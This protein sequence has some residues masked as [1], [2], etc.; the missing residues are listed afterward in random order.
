MGTQDTTMAYDDHVIAFTAYQFIQNRRLTMPFKYSVYVKQPSL[1]GTPSAWD[2][3]CDS[4]E[5]PVLLVDACNKLWPDAIG[6]NIDPYNSGAEEAAETDEELGTQGFGLPEPEA[7]FVADAGGEV[8]K[9]ATEVDQPVI[10]TAS[11][12]GKGSKYAAD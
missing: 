7:G 8:H 11:V 5:D 12:P 4:N 6:Y 2:W 1:D 3:V 9:V 10:K